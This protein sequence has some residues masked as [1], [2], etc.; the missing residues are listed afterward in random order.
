MK[1]CRK[2]DK[3][4]KIFTVFNIYRRV[5]TADWET[6]DYCLCG[7][8]RY[9][10]YG[11]FRRISHEGNENYTVGLSGIDFDICRY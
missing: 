6:V 3:N 5:S 7:N 9:L 11:T 4:G 10:F 2:G 1:K 8:S